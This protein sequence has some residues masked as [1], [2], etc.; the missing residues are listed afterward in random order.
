MEIKDLQGKVI[1]VTDLPQSIIQV[2]EYLSYRFEQREQSLIDFETQRQTYWR[3]V[4]QQ[5]IILQYE[6]SNDPDKKLPE[7]ITEG[8]MG[9]W[10]CNCGDSEGFYTCDSQGNEMEPLIG[11]DW[12]GLYICTN[13]GRIIHGDTLQVIGQKE[14]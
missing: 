4:Y 13:C 11:S 5:L 3:D 12:N 2:K 8:S 9:A 6:N 10:V 14:Q 7:F 1:T